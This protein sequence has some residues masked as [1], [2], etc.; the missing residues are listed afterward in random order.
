MY[1]GSLPAIGKVRY[2]GKEVCC[3]IAQE[4]N[5]STPEASAEICR[6]AMPHFAI[7]H[8]KIRPF[9][10]IENNLTIKCQ[11]PCSVFG[12]IWVCPISQTS[13]RLEHETR[14]KTTMCVNSFI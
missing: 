8:I 5:I 3:A 12:F 10:L 13:Q 4:Y 11:N 7:F 9:I 14:C 6:C 1:I 2:H